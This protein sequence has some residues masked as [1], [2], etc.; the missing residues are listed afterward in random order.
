MNTVQAQVPETR[1]MICLLAAVGLATANLS[2]DLQGHQFLV[3]SVRTGDTEV[4][5][6]DPTSGDATNLTRSPGSEDRYPCWSSDGRRF[7]FTSDRDGTFNLY[8]ADIEG[9]PRVADLAS[10][11]KH[12]R[13]AMGPVCTL[14]GCPERGQ[15]PCPSPVYCTSWAT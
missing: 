9:Q 2:P 5:R 12:R 11:H 15:T 7:A 10:E 14:R 1:L 3:T 8:V 6:V 4:F 13:S